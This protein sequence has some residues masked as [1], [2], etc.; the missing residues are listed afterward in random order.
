MDP[1]MLPLFAVAT[2]AAILYVRAWLDIPRL[3]ALR[4]DMS[5]KGE[6][7]LSIVIIAVA[8]IAAI[9]VITVMG[10]EVPQVLT[11]GLGSVLFGIAGGEVT[12]RRNE[13]KAGEAVHPA[14]S[15]RKTPVRKD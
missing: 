12:L 1:T 13:L 14:R 8:L 9:A 11:Q 5:E 4:D 10:Q 2:L 7:S 3:R 15:T 6:A